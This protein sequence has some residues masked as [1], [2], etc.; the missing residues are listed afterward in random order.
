M[1]PTGLP[2]GT[3]H[4]PIQHLQEEGCFPKASSQLSFLFMS[5][6]GKNLLNSSSANHEGDS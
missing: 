5:Q 2:A 6:N 1:A 4:D 3:L